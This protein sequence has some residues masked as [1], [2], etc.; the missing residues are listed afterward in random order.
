VRIGNQVKQIRTSLEER[1]A[2]LGKSG[3]NKQTVELSAAVRAQLKLVRSDAEQLATVA[4]K[5]SEKIRKKKG[6]KGGGLSDEDQEYVDTLNEVVDL[7][8]KHIEECVMLEKRRH[9]GDRVFDLDEDTGPVVS[10]LPE[11]DDDGPLGQQFKLLKQRDQEI[12]KGLDR[13]GKG[14]R[15]LKEMAE[16]IGR[17]AELQS[18]M[19][20]ELHEQTDENAE[21]VDN[22]NRRLKGVLARVRGGSRFCTDFICVLVILVLCGAIFQLISSFTG[23]D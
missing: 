13:I 20:S 7:A 1:D 18:A 4:E 15:V 3:G 10:T 2:L 8:F 11:I 14:V 17:E 12:D 19:L 9:G 16:E 21:L 22:L 6:K 5:K 23:D